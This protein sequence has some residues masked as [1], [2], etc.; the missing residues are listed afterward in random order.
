M[1]L[2]FSS[3]GKK[4]SMLNYNYSVNHAINVIQGDA[5]KNE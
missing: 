3:N 4:Y 2:M 5:V 1:L